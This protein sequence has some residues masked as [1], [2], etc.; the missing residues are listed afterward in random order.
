MAFL[1]IIRAYTCIYLILSI[2]EPK[3]TAEMTAQL[4][5]LMV[6]T[7][8]TSRLNHT[9]QCMC[10]LLVFVVLYT[11]T[12]INAIKNLTAPPISPQPSPSNVPASL[13]E[14]SLSSLSKSPTSTAA[15]T[16]ATKQ[17]AS[18]NNNAP[19]KTPMRSAAD[20]ATF[21]DKRVQPIATND[22]NNNQS[23]S[24]AQV[25]PSELLSPPLPPSSSSCSATVNGADR[26]QLTQ[27]ANNDTIIKKQD[28]TATQVIPMKAK[29]EHVDVAEKDQVAQP[30]I[31]VQTPEASHPQQTT[32]TATATTKVGQATATAASEER[33]KKE[34]YYEEINRKGNDLMAF[35]DNLQRIF[36]EPP[37]PSPDNHVRPFSMIQPSTAY[38]DEAIST[39]PAL[40]PPNQSSAAGSTLSRK[41]SMA[42][43]NS[44]LKSKLQQAFQKVTRSSTINIT[45]NNKQQQQQQHN[46]DI[47]AVP[48]SSPPEP[49]KSKRFSSIRFS[50]R[51][52]PKEQKAAAAEVSNNTHDAPTPKKSISTPKNIQVDLAA[53]LSSQVSFSNQGF[54]SAR[55][56]QSKHSSRI[57]FGM[58]SDLLAKSDANIAIFD[59]LAKF[60]LK[61]SY[62]T[63]FE[64]PNIDHDAAPVGDLDT[65]M[66]D[67]EYNGR[68]HISN[69]PQ[70][71]HLNFDTGSADIWV[72]ASDCHRCGGQ[73]HYDSSLSGSFRTE[74]IENG[75]W[76]VR[77]GD[78]S[79]VS[80]IIG[81]DTITLG[82][83]I[84]LDS[85]VFGIAKEQ[86]HG[87]ARG[88]FMDGLFNLA[89]PALSAISNRTGFVQELHHQAVPLL[90]FQWNNNRF[91]KCGVSINGRPIYNE[92]GSSAILD[93]GTTL[94][95]MPT[96]VSRKIHE[97]IPGAGFDAL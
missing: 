92:A 21:H 78:G 10:L 70:E 89:F 55:L 59:A 95:F 17:T 24:H 4:M 12:C 28:L 25:T 40:T 37:T 91:G 7:G 27:L 67:V 86:A 97:A 81:Q 36:D 35:S 15:P 56:V 93:T 31:P 57:V 19:T 54:I 73:R 80:G 76:Q 49:S 65:A 62:D 68:I 84:S 44:V 22:N 87:F 60:D 48:A 34:Q 94:L 13:P 32:P 8:R 5:E 38:L 63:D 16:V 77:Y 41:S 74:T 42:S 58:D 82:S 2:I 85:Y 46:D 66:M 3:Q 30:A 14:Q 18:K 51:K 39:T 29:E 47:A 71:L 6:P 53:K 79:G 26:D 1:S 33:S 90:T 83:D 52:A 45:P 43:Q 72:P 23:T 61:A 75:T 50:R 20:L 9:V 96:A 69:P 11:F 88:P 64:A